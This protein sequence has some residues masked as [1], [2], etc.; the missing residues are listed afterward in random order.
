MGL[1]GTFSL[2]KVSLDLES[3]GLNR[4]PD[5]RLIP[6]HEVEPLSHDGTTVHV[7]LNICILDEK[8]CKYLFKLFYKDVLSTFGDT[9]S[10]FVYLG[11]NIYSTRSYY[12]LKTLCWI[13]YSQ[14]T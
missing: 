12:L 11:K 3:A 9:K 7:R 8:V 4:L 1:T 13:S 14:R 2:L 10:F 5:H 6:K